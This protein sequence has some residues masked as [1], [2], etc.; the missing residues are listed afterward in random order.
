MVIVEDILLAARPALEEILTSGE[1]DQTQVDVVT[2]E[3]EPVMPATLLRENLLLR[4]IVHDEQIRIWLYPTEG[5]I[6]FKARLRS[7]LQD[8]VADSGF[9]WGELRGDV[10]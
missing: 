9:G 5:A 8:L 2:T 10:R 7:D 4:V 1:L 6:D 3:N